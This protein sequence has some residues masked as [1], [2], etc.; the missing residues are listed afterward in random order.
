MSTTFASPEIRAAV[1]LRLGQLGGVILA[2]VA[3]LLLLALISYNPHDPSLNTATSRRPTNLVG[4]AGATTADLLLQS[5]GL[6][7]LLPVLALVAW[8]WRLLNS[9]RAQ[10]LVRAVATLLDADPA[11]PLAALDEGWR[12]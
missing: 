4:I 5:F 12:A 9:P 7:A 1:R 8:S 2:V 3:L 11:E 10:L 6:A